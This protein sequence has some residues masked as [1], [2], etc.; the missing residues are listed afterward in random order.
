[1]L[2]PIVAAGCGQ[3]F[4]KTNAIEITSPSE[5]RRVDV[6]FSLRWTD[7]RASSAGGYA[8]FV[9][10][11]PIAPGK[12]LDSLAADDDLCETTPGCPDKVWY[13]T[14]YVY[15][16]NR[17][18]AKIPAMPFVSRQTSEARDAKDTYRVTVVRLDGEGRRLGEDYATVDI[19]ADVL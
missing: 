14:R 8:V 7:D 18:Q 12:R 11:P 17:R 19:R 15:P 2:V 9:D 3:Q 16:T 4:E 1:V 6:P 13:Q 5:L 10:S